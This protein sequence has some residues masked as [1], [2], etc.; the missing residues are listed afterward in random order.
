[1]FEIDDI[2]TIDGTN[3]QINADGESLG[4]NRDNGNTGAELIRLFE[5]DF[6]DD[7]NEP[8][9]GGVGEESSLPNP[10][11]ISNTIA[12]QG[13]VTG[14]PLDASDWL[15]QWGQFLDHDLGLSEGTNILR[16]E[17][18][19]QK[20]N[21]IFNIPLPEDDILRGANFTAIPV[22]RVPAVEGT[23]TGDRPRAV[24]NEITAYID[25]SNGYGSDIV[26]AAAKRSDLGNSFFGR[27]ADGDVR[28]E[29]ETGRRFVEVEIDEADNVELLGTDET[30]EV[31]ADEVVRIYLPPEGESPYDGKLLVA[32]DNYG[33]DGLP[34]ESP[35]D[36]TNTSGEILPPYNRADSANADPDPDPESS[37]EGRVPNNDEFIS[38]DVRINE[39]SGLISIHTLLI[40]EH[41]RVADKVAFHLDA[42]DD[43][44][45]NQAFADFRDDYVPALE[46]E[47]EPSA[48]QIRGEFIYEA[49]RA[50]IGAK[51]QVITYEEFLPLLVGNESAADLEV[52]DEDILSPAI[53]TEFSGAAYRLGHTLIS[54]QIRTVDS[55]G[56]DRI[57]LREAF[58]TPQ[59]ISAD[60]VDNVLIGLNYQESNDAD[61]RIIDGIR[62]NLFGPPGAGGLDLAAINIQR[63]RDLGIPSYTEVYNQLNPDAPINDFD[64][65]EPIFGADLAARFEEA[66]DN[67]DQIDLWLGGLAELPAEEGA[68]LGPTL[69]AIVSDQ[70]ARLRDYDRFFYEDQLAD[71]DS[72]LSVV[73][74]AT[75]SNVGEVRL[76]DIIRANVDTPELVPDDAFKVPFDNEII[77]TVNSDRNANQLSGTGEAD[78]IDGQS[79]DDSIVGGAG[80][81]VIFGGAGNDTLK[82]ENGRDTLVGGAGND[83]L[84]DRSGSVLSGGMGNDTYQVSPTSD[85]AGTQITDASGDDDVLTFDVGSGAPLELSLTSIRPGVSGVKKSGNDLIADLN[86]DGI[87]ES[88][89]DLVISDY[90]NNEA[91]AGSGA[92]EELANLSSDEIINY[93]DRTQIDTGSNVFRL[94]NAEDDIYRYTTSSTERTRLRNN[95]FTGNQLAYSSAPED[96]DLDSLTGAKPVYLFANE[97]TQAHLFT[98]NEEERDEILANLPNL[99]YEGIAYYA[100][101]TEQPDT[102]PVYRFLNTENGSHFYTT[103]RAEREDFASDD[104]FV[105]EGNEG[106]AFYV[107]EG[108]I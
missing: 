34:F 83:L 93:F 88:S 43:E 45:L 11:D 52:I 91:G 29:E 25:G 102:I 68:L 14:N 98:T 87:I 47:S 101:E 92:I 23:G 82:G 31:E 42:G 89:E 108:E 12:P 104:N 50:I 81:D 38:G 24:E 62:N 5:P 16:L 96:D 6:A 15:W 40:R 41:N 39:Q 46:L 13:N 36:P 35:G 103:S 48:E 99:E 20:A 30:A 49:S 76:A 33:T 95:G 63:G 1:M 85:S 53:S 78:L 94:Y 106:I 80:N 75:D 105:A 90:F 74:N 66:Y 79:G 26:R 21:A 51:S 64:D 32:N 72:F 58:F 100:Y 73:S 65:L 17:N 61:P 107:P 9:G 22:S 19:A 18:E 2:R 67:V 3:N 70:F 37:T 54:D 86:Q 56:I 8:R 97:D 4:K 44:A 77:G 7:L 57:S 59:A 10:R 28:V 71:P 27:F 60:G 55:E 84:R 69:G